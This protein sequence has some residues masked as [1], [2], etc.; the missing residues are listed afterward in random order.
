MFIKWLIISCP[1]E[2]RD[3][4]CRCFLTT[5][6]TFFFAFFHA[7]TL[8]DYGPTSRF[9][10][11]VFLNFGGH[12]ATW[13]RVQSY[14]HFNCIWWHFLWRIREAICVL[15][16]YG[17][18][19]IAPCFH[20]KPFTMERWRRDDRDDGHCR[21]LF[22]TPNKLWQEEAAFKSK[23]KNFWSEIMEEKYERLKITS[24]HKKHTHPYC[25]RTEAFHIF[26]KFSQFRNSFDF[27][28]ATI[29]LFPCSFNL[30]LS[31]TC[32]N[33][34]CLK[35]WLIEMLTEVLGS[36]EEFDGSPFEYQHS[37][38]WYLCTPFNTI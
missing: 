36:I 30:F 29:R 31:I 2:H 34:L 24:I 16:Y 35:L 6:G 23:G 33:K 5:G 8:W 27:L 13:H 11:L 3:M 18:L 32:Y 17:V 28:L 1:S 4:S 26:L 10:R 20:V 21:C 22:N 25:S 37:A 38:L 15:Y 14:F 7:Y 19:K 9:N 12:M